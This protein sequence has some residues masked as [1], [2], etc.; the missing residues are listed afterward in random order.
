MR[1]V[2]GRQA[3]DGRL[4][5]SGPGRSVAPAAA[6]AAAAPPAPRLGLAA[7]SREA[8]DRALDFLVSRLDQES[9]R[10]AAQ[11]KSWLRAQEV[12]AQ[13]RAG[14]GE[15]GWSQDPG[16][17]VPQRVATE[18]EVRDVFPEA[19]LRELSPELLADVVVDALTGTLSDALVDGAVALTARSLVSDGVED[20]DAAGAR[21]PAVL[22]ACAS[23][24]GLRPSKS[25]SASR[26]A[27]PSPVLKGTWEAGY[28]DPVRSSDGF[29]TG[30]LA[31]ECHQA[32]LA[33]RF[34]ASP[35]A[36]T[37]PLAR[38]QRRVEAQRP[39][40][41]A[42]QCTPDPEHDQRKYSWPMTRSHFPATWQEVSTR[43]RTRGSTE[44]PGEPGAGLLHLNAEGRTMFPYSLALH[45]AFIESQR[46]ELHREKARNF[47]PLRLSTAQEMNWSED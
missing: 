7:F 46:D 11:V 4:G 17:D 44:P 40:R 2:R 28:A 35:A 18:L 20:V 14:L 16:K 25:S 34:H 26:R 15:L 24:P 29:C 43:Q 30:G 23:E 37:R 33:K 39:R 42:A 8:A 27:G 10:Q 41:R 36:H 38:L 3:S 13:V 9:P 45:K 21:R 12:H 47:A 31:Q 6:T 5:G 1:G 19:W 22:S 32:W